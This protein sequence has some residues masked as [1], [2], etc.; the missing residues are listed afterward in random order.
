VASA[1]AMESTQRHRF[2]NETL[3]QAQA[4]LFPR[5]AKSQRDSTKVGCAP[6]QVDQLSPSNTFKVLSATIEKEPEYESSASDFWQNEPSLS[7]KPSTIADD[8]VADAVAIH[9]YIT[10][11]QNLVATIKDI[12]TAAADKKISLAAVAWLTNMAQTHLRL[13]ENHQS[14]RF[15]EPV[16]IHLKA[17]IP[18]PTQPDLSKRKQAVSPVNANELGSLAEDDRFLEFTLG[19]YSRLG[20]CLA[21]Q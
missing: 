7:A 20:T 17:F 14:W 2:F 21:G 19:V 13:W 10:E 6:T 3:A 16:L 11:L 9:A 1:E 15:H 8:V 4:L 18:G 5:L 12:W